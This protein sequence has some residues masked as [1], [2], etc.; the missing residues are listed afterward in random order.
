MSKEVVEKTASK[1]RGVPKSEEHLKKMR[2]MY[3]DRVASKLS[4]RFCHKEM[5]KNGFGSHLR[6]C[7]LYKSYKQE[8]R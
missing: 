5:S 2:E 8:R 1:L 3:K 6:F 7:K 4:C